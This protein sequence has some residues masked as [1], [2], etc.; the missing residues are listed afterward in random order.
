MFVYACMGANLDCSHKLKACQKV[1]VLPKV[2]QNFLA[3]VI[4]K[5]TTKSG[6][7]KL[8]SIRFNGEI[9]SSIYLNL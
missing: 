6:Y 4:K 1:F 9:D 2:R 7:S 5:T 8:L 3:E